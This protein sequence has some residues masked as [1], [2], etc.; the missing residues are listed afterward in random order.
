M[1]QFLYLNEYLILICKQCAYAIPPTF[2]TSHL[3]RHLHGFRGFENRAALSALEK[4]L[5]GLSLVNL[6][7]ENVVFLILIGLHC[8]KFR[9][10]T[11]SNVGIAYILLHHLPG[12]RK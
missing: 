11:A 10:T 7:E 1:E 4:H 2:L 8:R 6:L 5:L 3:K 9:C 12:S